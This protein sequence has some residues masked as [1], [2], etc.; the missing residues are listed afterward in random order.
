[1]S[2]FLRGHRYIR[3]GFLTFSAMLSIMALSTGSAR[4]CSVCIAHAIGAALQRIGAQTF[5]RGTFVAG[6]SYLTFGKSSA[7][8]DPGTLENEIYH[9]TSLDLSYG[10]TDRLLLQASLPFVNKHIQATGQPAATANGLGDMSFGAVYQLPPSPHRKMLAAFNLD[11]KL[12]TGKND[13]RDAAGNLKDQH[14]QPGTGSADVSAGV[15][16]TWEGKRPG[17]LWFTGLGI[18]R[19]G[20]NSRGYHFGNVLFYNFGYARPVDRSSALVLEFDGRIAGKD[21]QE[22]GTLDSNSGGHLGY[23]ALSYRRN[24]VYGIGL[25]ASYQFPVLSHLN[26]VQKERPLFSLSLS[27]SF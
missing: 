18:R 24:L 22:D 15:N 23:L 13:L 27:R 3:T 9:Q 25:I 6:V 14:L 2:A 26:G 4:A 11:L 20:S 17:S 21:R 7:G 5:P 8:D 1:M 10:M 19:N 16:F 12:P